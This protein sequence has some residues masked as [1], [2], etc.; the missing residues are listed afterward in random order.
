M[1]G[2]AASSDGTSKTPAHY[3]YSR[4]YNRVR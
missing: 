4:A 2:G 3:V 1:C